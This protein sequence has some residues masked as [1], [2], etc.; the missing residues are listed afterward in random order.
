MA[1]PED[2]IS[3]NLYE[4]RKPD[5]E[6]PSNFHGKGRIDRVY[7]NT[8]YGSHPSSFDILL[9]MET[10]DAPHSHSL[11]V[12]DTIGTGMELA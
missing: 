9:T 6:R 5:L 8:V 12:G 3:P 7:K 10:G 2:W 11:S 1:I 4:N